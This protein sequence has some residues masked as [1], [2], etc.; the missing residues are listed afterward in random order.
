ML[1]KWR[2]KELSARWFSQCCGYE[3]SGLGKGNYSTVGMISLKAGGERVPRKAAS[4]AIHTP[5]TFTPVTLG[6]SSTLVSCLD[7]RRHGEHL[8]V[9]ERK[10]TGQKRP[11]SSWP[12]ASGTS[13]LTRRISHLP[14]PKKCLSSTAI[15]AAHISTE[16]SHLLYGSRV[17]GFSILFLY[18]YSQGST[19]SSLERQS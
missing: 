5:T 11:A 6:D 18:S 8:K 12:Q 15:S 7:S 9:G 1:L 3:G 19:P 14:I 13:I 4:W 16:I 2:H 10:E 17:G